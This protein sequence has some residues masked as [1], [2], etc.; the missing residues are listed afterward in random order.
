MKRNKKKIIIGVVTLIAAMNLA[1]IFLKP[2]IVLR[3]TG[4]YKEENIIRDSS[5]EGKGDAS[6]K[7][8]HSDLTFNGK[9]IFD[10]MDGVNATDIDGTDI[11]D[12]VA[13]S[14]VSGEVINKK[15]IRYVVFDSSGESL[16]AECALV[17]DGYRGPELKVGGVTKVSFNDLETLPQILIK[18][19][20]LSGTDGFGSDISSSISY[21]YELDET[22]EQAKLTFSLTNSFQ[23][24]VSKKIDVIVTDIPADFNGGM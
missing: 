6:L 22:T 14:F 16:E 17:L 4:L 11:T 20:V 21:G 12:K 3:I 24:F 1:V 9:G 15:K 5:M 10:P 2:D 18:E 13:V 19:G 23:D 8:E 7:I